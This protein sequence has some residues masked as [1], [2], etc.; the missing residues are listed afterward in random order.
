[1]FPRIYLTATKYAS[2]LYVKELGYMIVNMIIEAIR[3]QIKTCGK[4]RY[5]IAKETSVGEDQL[6]RIMQGK[7]C[8]V[9]T[10]D[11]LLKYFGLTIAK[12]KRRKSR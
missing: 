11:I 8:T 7:T 1:M 5:R 6:C 2:I 3:R 12:N 10:A 9:E 4:T